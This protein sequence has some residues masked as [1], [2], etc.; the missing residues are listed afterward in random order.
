MYLETRDVQMKITSKRFAFEY[1]V[2]ISFLKQPFI[3]VRQKKS[4]SNIIKHSV[5]SIRN[6]TLKLGVLSQPLRNII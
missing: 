4:V 5:I 2:F 6:G 3:N 1:F